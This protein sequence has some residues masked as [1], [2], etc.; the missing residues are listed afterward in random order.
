MTEKYEGDERRRQAWHL[1]Q[2][3]PIALFVVLLGQ[4][5]SGVW[6]ASEINSA[7]KKSTEDTATL[8]RA[9]TEMQQRE[10]G[11]GTLVDRPVRGATIMETVLRTVNK[12]DDVL[13]ERKR[14]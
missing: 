11:K 12:I 6:Y 4:I 13:T 7:V 14:K 3:V 1:D 5:L 2:R 10:R 9:I 8:A